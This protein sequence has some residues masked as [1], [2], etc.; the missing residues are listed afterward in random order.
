MRPIRRHQW[1]SLLG[2]S[3][4]AVLLAGTPAQ[5]LPRLHFR[6]IYS[7]LDAQSGGKNY[8]PQPSCT[9]GTN[10]PRCDPP[11]S[12]YGPGKR[13]GGGGFALGMSGHYPLVRFLRLSVAPFVEGAGF[14]TPDDLDGKMQ[15]AAWTGAELWYWILGGRLMVGP[16]VGAAWFRGHVDKSMGGGL[17][18]CL[19]CSV[20]EG[21]GAFRRSL[22]RVVLKRSGTFREG[23]GGLERYEL[24]IVLRPD[25]W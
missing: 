5:A 16:S 10:T 11:P 3:L 19:S 20:P 1:V 21:A 14:Y 25:V 18:W 17:S 24:G 13:M 8:S 22:D 12:Y 2:I 15:F 9:P 7:E 23:Q 4:F 6:L